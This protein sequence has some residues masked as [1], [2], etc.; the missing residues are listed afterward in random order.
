MRVLA[1]K[2]NTGTTLCRMVSP[3]SDAHRAMFLCLA[4]S[5]LQRNYSNTLNDIVDQ[6][7]RALELVPQLLSHA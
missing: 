6:L 2:V 4:D 5:P 7:G 1:G 3:V